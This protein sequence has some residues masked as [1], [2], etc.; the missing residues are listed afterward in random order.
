MFP[1]MVLELMLLLLLWLVV[2]WVEFKGPF[3]VWVSLK[4]SDDNRSWAC[5]G[6]TVSHDTRVVVA[7]VTGGST[8]ISANHFGMRRMGCGGVVDR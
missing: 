1:W 8:D 6:I 5:D 7:E 3:L 2:F 4:T